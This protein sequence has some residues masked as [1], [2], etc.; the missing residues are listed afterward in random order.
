MLDS[1][2]SSLIRFASGVTNSFSDEMEVQ[3][4]REPLGLKFKCDWGMEWVGVHLL[5][6]FIRKLIIQLQGASVSRA[7]S[8][9]VCGG[10]R[11]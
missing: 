3:R 1:R 7:V 11:V 2:D 9:C 4:K 10:E 6:A 5:R 8:V